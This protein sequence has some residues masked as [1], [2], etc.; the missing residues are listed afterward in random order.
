MPGTS[1]CLCTR[2]TTIWGVLS[3]HPSG[4]GVTPSV[5]GFTTPSFGPA[6]FSSDA[7]WAP[8]VS[9]AVTIGWASAH[10]GLTADSLMM[11]RHPLC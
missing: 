11:W 3:E 4:A 9:L 8:G 7:R 1:G 2:P 10:A 5:R 6:C